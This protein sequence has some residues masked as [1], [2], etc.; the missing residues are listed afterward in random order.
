MKLNVIAASTV[1]VGTALLSPAT[2]SAGDFEQAVKA[3]T[4]GET[5]EKS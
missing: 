3:A 2:S 5:A 1:L 4:N